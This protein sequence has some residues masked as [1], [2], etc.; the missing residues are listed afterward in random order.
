MQKVGFLTSEKWE[1]LTMVEPRLCQRTVAWNK[2]SAAS[3]N[4]SMVPAFCP[5]FLVLY[6]ALLHYL[7]DPVEPHASWTGKRFILWAG[8]PSVL[9]TDASVYFRVGSQGNGIRMCLSSPHFLPTP[10]SVSTN[11]SFMASREKK[12]VKQSGLPSTRLYRIIQMNHREGVWTLHVSMGST[13]YCDDALG[14]Y[15][16]RSWATTTAPK[17][18]ANPSHFRVAKN[19]YTSQ[20]FHSVLFLS[21]VNLELQSHSWLPSCS[22]PLHSQMVEAS[23]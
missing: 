7:S 22:W 11:W 17:Q 21:E 10:V 16:P 9:I 18:E 20:L 15:E 4:H 3:L 19:G 5:F 14:K 1:D 6:W 13:S 12:M 2:V 23:R 8:L